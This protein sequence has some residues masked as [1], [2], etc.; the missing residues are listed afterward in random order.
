MSFNFFPVLQTKKA[1]YVN[2][3]STVKMQYVIAPFLPV[4]WEGIDREPGGGGG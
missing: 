2:A 3:T 1:Q 4:R